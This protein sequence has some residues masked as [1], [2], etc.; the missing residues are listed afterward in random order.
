MATHKVTSCFHTGSLALGLAADPPAPAAA[1][2]DV[3]PPSQ[4]FLSS[5]F[6]V[7][8]PLRSPG[9]ASLPLPN[10][11]LLLRAAMSNARLMDPMLRMP[12]PTGVGG[13]DGVY[14]AD[15]LAAGSSAFSIGSRE[16]N[17]EFSNW[18]TTYGREVARTSGGMA[19]PRPP[20]SLIV[21]WPLMPT[22]GEPDRGD[23]AVVGVWTS[24][25]NRPCEGEAVPEY[26][27]EWAS[28]GWVSDRDDALGEVGRRRIGGAAIRKSGGWIESDVVGA[29][30]VPLEGGAAV[31]D[32]REGRARVGRR[33]GRQRPARWEGNLEG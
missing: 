26:E 24:G 5:P 20:M 12:P 4:S 25:G 2:A 6:G 14:F 7:V 21:R 29:A 30:V 27:C 23:E 19:S 10:P 18:T 17:S 15:P 8:A 31:T 22:F 13:A 1:D 3:R 11:A 28:W 16:T 9:S 32:E 33:R